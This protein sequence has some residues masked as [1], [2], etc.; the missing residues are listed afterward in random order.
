MYAVGNVLSGRSY[1]SVEGL[2]DLFWS[3]INFIV[4]L[5]VLAWRLLKLTKLPLWAWGRHTHVH[6][7]CFKWMSPQILSQCSKCDKQCFAVCLQ[8]EDAVQSWLQLQPQHT[9]HRLQKEWTVSCH[10]FI[11]KS[12]LGQLYWYTVDLLTTNF[13]CVCLQGR[14]KSS[15]G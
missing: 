7:L 3:I 9:H 14:E 2:L 4:L 13:L 11:N 6:K 5:W 1:W 12:C 10:S 15:D 8:F